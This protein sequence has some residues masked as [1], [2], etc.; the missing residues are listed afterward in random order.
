[1]IYLLTETFYSAT[2]IYKAIGLEGPITLDRGETITVP[3]G[4]AAFPDPH[5]PPPPPEFIARSHNL[6]RYTPMPRGGHFPALEESS[7]IVEDIQGFI[8]DLR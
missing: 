8:R 7:L 1:M 4:F 3:V 2:T 6:V 5:S